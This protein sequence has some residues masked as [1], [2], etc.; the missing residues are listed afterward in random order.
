MGGFSRKR[1]RELFEISDEYNIIAIVAVGYYGDREALTEELKKREHP[2]TRKN[3][4]EICYW[5]RK[6]MKIGIVVHSHTG[7]PL[8]CRKA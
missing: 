7:K 5:R 2:D 1:A 3:I 4:E 8:I 6:K